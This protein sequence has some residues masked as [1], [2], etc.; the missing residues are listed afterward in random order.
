MNIAALS[1]RRPI[2]IIILVA[3]CL[4]FGFISI[5]RVGLDL[6][7]EINLPMAA[8]ITI[9]P[10]ADPRTVEQTVSIPIERALRSLRG[11]KD[12]TSM[13]VEN[14]A[15]ALAE[16]NWGT[17]LESAQ[18]QIR[19]NLDTMEY[20]L[21]EGVQ[22]PIVSLIDLSQLPVLTLT[23]GVP[24]DITDVTQVV[25]DLVRPAIERVDGIAGVSVSGAAERIISVA[26]DYQKL[27]DAALSPLILQQLIAMQNLSVPAGVVLDSGVR[28]QT[29]VGTGYQSAEDIAGLT[30]GVKK[31]DEGTAQGGGL[32]GLSLLMP[33]FL[34]VG[35]VAEVKETAASSEGFSR[36][37]GKPAVMLMVQKQGGQNTVTA[38]RKVRGAL[39]AL[40]AANPE[41]E[42]AYVFDQS[43]VINTSLSS[44]W[45]NILQG[46]VLA[47]IVLWLFLRNVRSTM[48]IALSIPLSIVFTLV[49]MYASSLN[50]NLLTLG[51][52]ALGV[53][54]LVD[55]SIV[56]LESIFRRQELGDSPV[57]AA[58]NGVQEVGMAIVATTVTTIVVFVPIVFLESLVGEIFKE[59]ALTVIYS[60]SA[61]LVVAFTVVPLLSVYLVRANAQAPKGVTAAAAA[62][63]KPGRPGR[64]PRA[65]IGE[66]YER[67]LAASMK[68]R[69]AVLI[70][71]LLA[72]VAAAFVAPS[73]GVELFPSM[74]MGRID[75]QAFL[76]AGT[77]VERTDEMA[78]AVEQALMGIGGVEV[79]TSE[80]GSTG[81]GD[82]M[83]VLGG[84]SANIAK[85]SLGLVKEGPDARTVDAV[86]SDARAAM[87][88]VLADYEGAEFKTDAS[89]WGSFGSSTSSI[90]GGAVTIEIRG[91]DSDKI[92]QHARN[93]VERLR[94]VPGFVEVM[95]DARDAQPLMLLEINRTRAL[96]GGLTVGQVGL[97]V[98]TSMLGTTATYV[99]RGGDL[100]PVV[101]KPKS[102]GPMTL[103]Q[104]LEMPI[105]ASAA[106]A[107]GSMT[108][109][110]SQMGSNASAA[111]RSI[112]ASTSLLTP[113]T[114]VLVGR[115]A[116]PVAVDGPVSLTR[117]NG[118]PYT[119]VKVGFE[120]M[121]LAR[122]SDLAM[123]A[124]A[125]V[126]RPEGVV[127]AL[128]GI[129]RVLADAM[130]D[131]VFVAVLAVVLVYM[132]MAIQYEA[133]LY[134][135]IVMFT[136]PLALIGA[137]GVLLMF[138][139][140]L[141][142]MAIIG[143][144][145]L[146]GVV[147]DNG[148]VMIDFISQLKAAGMASTEAVREASRVRLRP[149]LMTALTTILGLLPTAIGM[150]GRGSELQ[151]PLALTV[152]G[153]LTVAT[154][155][156]LF[157]IPMLY[158]LIDNAL[159]KRRG[160]GY[161]K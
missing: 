50:L 38:A 87:A 65:D 92:I 74:D 46:G 13:S 126:E 18:Q 21:P 61:S 39:D 106:S 62:A 93:V 120:G 45:D 84:S 78:V 67:M 8:I 95:S 103:E 141:G 142:V 80:V 107:T 88:R 134:P 72:F 31:R 86:V 97:G 101:V 156:T 10:N 6:L 2:T 26:Y 159:I 70:I 137:V 4:M 121:K 14:M 110:A 108:S 91:D 111:A 90:M 36:V 157:V 96:M 37:N 150:G 160:R 158:E 12:V 15:I 154:F 34:T 55:A 56:V 53:G 58:I 32:F 135:F 77:P 11:I 49:M 69:N 124:A 73:L 109:S 25:R 23:V 115:V 66:V 98:R 75:I 54:M 148:I 112:E 132:V 143:L 116:T 82:Y 29:R 151:R 33:Q 22:R 144:I 57:D 133:L 27:T 114:E 44:L 41:I 51:G 119:I 130:D 24:G 47:V 102:E 71:C 43:D 138:G 146:A 68:H 149:I 85:F 7:P 42:I 161:V 35:D 48:V 9:Y 155:L 28:Y 3:A 127:L 140:P 153:G 94:Q 40:V 52:L 17:N 113:P 139:E 105:S 128:G 20:S 1:I 136:L 100:I 117:R 63:G 89:G 79:V 129:N 76:P 131:M 122:A 145:V 19:T 59:L 123:K 125:E 64:R 60:L 83:S 99:E 147:V 104:L 30:I 118:V 81:T 152:I 16:F 5:G